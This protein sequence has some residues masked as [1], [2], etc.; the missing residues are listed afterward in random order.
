[1]REKRNTEDRLNSVLTSTLAVLV[2]T[3]KATQTDSLQ[4][5]LLKLLKSIKLILAA[6]VQ[7]IKNK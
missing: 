1:M 4:T 7:K 3:L 5:A 2:L 6:T